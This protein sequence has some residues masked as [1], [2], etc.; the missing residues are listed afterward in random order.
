MRVRFDRF[1]LD[2]E[3]RELLRGDARVSL[4]PKAFELLELLV[5]HRPKAMAKHDLLERLWPKTFVVEKNLPNLI[6]E[7]RDA[8]GDDSTTPRFIRTIH[9]FGYAFHG[10]SASAETSEAARRAGTASFLLK[11]AEGRVTIREGTHVLGRDPEGDIFLNH[12]GISRRHARI[13][14]SGDQAV[15][16]DLSSKNGTFVGEQRI[17]AARVLADGDVVT[18]GSVKLTFAVVTRPDST[19]TQQTRRESET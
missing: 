6:G 19:E 18:V 14:V 17:H 13:T 11:W 8:L 3:T 7:I 12:P 9:R 2:T 4:S 5:A 10:A 16:E 1:V 15:L